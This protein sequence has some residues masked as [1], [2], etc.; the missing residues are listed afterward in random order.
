[1]KLYLFYKLPSEEFADNNPV[2]YA[3]TTNKELADDFKRQRN[4]D[5]FIFRK[6]AYFSK[7]EYKKFDE[8]YHKHELSYCQFYTKSFVFGKKIPVKVLCTWKEEETILINSDRMWEEYSKHLFDTQ[9]LKSEY[10]IALEKLLFIRFYTFFKVKCVSN[11]DEFYDP[12]YSAYSSLG[13]LIVEEFKDNYSY[14]DF[15]LFLRFFKDTFS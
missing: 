11:L 14:D 6:E 1:M 8:K 2:L 12:Y 10:L 13:G 7:S 4:M 5:V 9:M 3:Y 15:K